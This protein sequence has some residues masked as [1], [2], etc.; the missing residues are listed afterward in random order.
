M[1][2]Q[3]SLNSSDLLEFASSSSSENDDE[4][5][6]YETIESVIGSKRRAKGQKSRPM[7]KR[8]AVEETQGKEPKARKAAW[9]P[10]KLADVCGC[11]SK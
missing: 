3:S 5:E 2:E 9:T 10:R 11:G 1:A 8:V 4:A 7:S 6:A